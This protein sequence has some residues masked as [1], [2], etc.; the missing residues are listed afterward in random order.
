MIWRHGRGAGAAK[1]VDNCVQELRRTA[2]LLSIKKRSEAD[3]NVHLFLHAMFQ[4]D[5][6]LSQQYHDLQIELYINY[7]KKKL[8][9]FL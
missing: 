1:L 8:L 5:K 2:E 4:I 7:D 9:N 6:T 3:Y